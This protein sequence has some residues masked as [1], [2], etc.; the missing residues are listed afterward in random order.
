MRFHLLRISLHSD[1][2]R[3]LFAA[4]PRFSTDGWQGGLNVKRGAHLLAMLECGETMICVL[5]D[6]RR[7]CRGQGPSAVVAA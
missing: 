1:G 3:R 5:W 6:N 7:S 4:V 2:G